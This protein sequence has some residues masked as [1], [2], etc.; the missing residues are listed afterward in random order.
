LPLLCPY[1]TDRV[2][3]SVAAAVAAADDDDNDN[4]GAEMLK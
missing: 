4:D 2:T 1:S 3:S